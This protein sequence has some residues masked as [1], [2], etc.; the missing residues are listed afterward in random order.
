MKR[1][2]FLKTACPAVAFGFFGITLLEA[3]SPSGDD[4]TYTDPSNSTNSTSGITVSGTN[5]SID[6]TNDTFSA[7][8]NTGGWMNILSQGLLVLRVS[9]TTVRAFSNCCP[10]QGTKNQWSYNNSKF[11]CGDHGN[12]YDLDGTI[13][14]CNSG[15]TSGALTSYEATLN[16]NSLNI[17]KA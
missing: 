3:C 4:N 8:R 7:L 9:S 17:V 5:V 14:S 6:L 13:S 15:K 16:G 2:E 11:R 12:S 1:K 10:H